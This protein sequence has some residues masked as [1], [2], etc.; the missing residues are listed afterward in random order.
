M[1]ENIRAV[2]EMKMGGGAPYRKT[3]VEVERY[4]QEGAESLTHQ[5]GMGH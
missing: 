2:V 4:C 3:E 5:G 1:Q